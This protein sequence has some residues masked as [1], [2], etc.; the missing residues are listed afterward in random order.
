MT[1]QQKTSNVAHSQQTADEIT[2]LEGE[3]LAESGEQ[4]I[5]QKSAKGRAYSESK[6][7][8]NGAH[9]GSRA[10]Q[11][12]NKPSWFARFRGYLLWILLFIVVILVLFATRP[13]TQWQIEHINNLQSEVSQLYQEHQTLESRVADQEAK[14][15]GSPKAIEA[16]IAEALTRSDNRPLVTQ[17]ELDELKKST[18]QQ[19]IEL[20]HR[21]QALKEVSGLPIEKVE[22]GNEPQLDSAIDAAKSSEMSEAS[23]KGLEEKLQAQ[24]DEMSSKLSELSDFNSHQQVLTTQQ[25]LSAFQIQQWITEINTQWLMQGRVE[26]TAQQL[27]ALEQVVGLSD[28]PEATTLARLIGQDLTHLESLQQSEQ[29]EALVNIQAL[30]AA[31]NKLS[32]NDSQGSKANSQSTAETSIASGSDKIALGDEI[33]SESAWDQLMTRFGQLVSLKKRET[34]TEQTQV[35]SLIMHDVLVQRGLLL[36]DRIDWA[37]ETKS[38]KGLS[39]AVADLQMFI[40]AHF[41]SQSRVFSSLLEPFKTLTFDLRQP[42]AIMTLQTEL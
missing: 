15:L 16:A 12:T 21:L 34:S 40:D 17:V 22:E 6:A 13:N 14:A 27:L 8:D 23:I 11:A 30:K 38:S 3:V 26:Q 32:A 33:S 31:V 41:A 1:K 35:E 7:K 42:L 19:L 5:E 2:V 4:S 18:Q 39:L 20:Q 9:S 36:V 24:I 29:P 10:N 25:P 28:F 37:V